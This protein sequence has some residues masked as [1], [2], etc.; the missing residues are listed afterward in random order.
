V[1]LDAQY[2]ASSAP[3]RDWID[4]PTALGAFCGLDLCEK[5]ILY[6]YLYLYWWFVYGG[7][8]QRGVGAAR[9]ATRAA[10]AACLQGKTITLKVE[11]PDSIDDVK[12]K[13]REKEG[14]PP[15]QQR[16]L[17]AG[18]QLGKRTPKPRCP[19]RR[20]GKGLRLSLTHSCCDSATS[21]RRSLCRR[22][23]LNL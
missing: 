3:L 2:R 5:Y 17:I 16:L 11:P 23:M 7:L 12:A 14:I 13:I 22:R 9:D 21:A 1:Q 8:W 18:Q 20:T 10:R 4:A 6:L 15:D 19:R